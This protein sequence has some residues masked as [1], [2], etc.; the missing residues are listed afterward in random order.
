MRGIKKLFILAILTIVLLYYYGAF[1][2]EY[3]FPSYELNES[4][5][6]LLFLKDVRILQITDDF[7]FIS[8]KT[9]NNLYAG[10]AN[11]NSASDMKLIATLLNNGYQSLSI[12]PFIFYVIAALVILLK[13]QNNIVQLP[14][15]QTITSNNS[16]STH[17]VSHNEQVFLQIPNSNFKKES[18]FKKIFFTFCSLL[19][20]ITALAYFDIFVSSSNGYI[21]E[22]TLYFSE[23]NF[24]TSDDFS[25]D[26]VYYE[27]KPSVNIVY[28]KYKV[29]IY[30]E[31]DIVLHEETVI[32][33]ELEKNTTYRYQVDIGF[34]NLLKAQKIRIK[35]LDGKK[36]I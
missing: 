26:K 25:L 20:V 12:L 6:E 13:K 5:L 16:D 3:G 31:S 23:I 33:Y 2:F 18:P 17:L 28:V 36:D 9:I 34:S 32:K 27:I 21:K 11:S 29:T 24:T 35:L 22:D 19:L 14:I 4:T 30:D 8:F 7:Y 15:T 1:S 10:F